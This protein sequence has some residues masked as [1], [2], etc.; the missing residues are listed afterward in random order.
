MDPRALDW[1]IPLLEKID[2]L[3]NDLKQIKNDF[4]R[5]L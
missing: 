3:K 2:P 4:S 1:I 5:E